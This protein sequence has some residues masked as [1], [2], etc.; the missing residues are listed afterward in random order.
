[1]PEQKEEEESAV[2]QQELVSGLAELYQTSRGANDKRGKK[3]KMFLF[4]LF[5][6]NSRVS[7][8][9]EKC[10]SILEILN[11]HLKHKYN[12]YF[13]MVRK[14]VIVYHLRSTGGAQRTPV[15]QKMKTMSRSLQ[16]LNVARLNVKAQKNQAEAEQIGVEGKG[17]E[18][19]GK[20]RSNDR[21]KSEGANTIS[22]C[23]AENFTTLFFC[24]K[25]KI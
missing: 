8:K 23:A 9:V 10:I 22:E 20:R 16:M 11:Y 1:M 2:L 19:R 14:F 15:K 6:L 3:R 24:K 7:V 4:V 17:P 5:N 18:R 12:S 25:V 13:R 21:N